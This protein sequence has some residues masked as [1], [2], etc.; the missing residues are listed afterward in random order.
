MALPTTCPFPTVDVIIELP[1]HPLSRPGEPAIVLIERRFP[2][3]GWALPGGF[4]DVG[5]PLWAAAAREAL[6]ETSLQVSLREQ[7]F[8]YSDPRRDERRHTIST[9]FIGEARGEPRAD[10]DAGRIGV[11][12][13]SALPALA[14]DH[15]QILA[16]YLRYRQ[17]GQRP[18]FNR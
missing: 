4:V 7:F 11:F 8:S 14:F 5:E 2:P 18:P 9:V 3:P 15:G 1:E 16:D 6:E 10:D 13:L 12:Q 17:T